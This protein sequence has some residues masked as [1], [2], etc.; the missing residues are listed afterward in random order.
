M[1]NYNRLNNLFPT[2]QDILDVKKFKA[3]RTYPKAIE[4][5]LAKQRAFEKKYAGFDLSKDGRNLMY[6]PLNLQV[7]PK[8]YKTMVLKKEYKRSF[9]SGIVNFYKTIREKFLNIKRTDV[10]AFIKGQQIPQLTDIMRHRTN[11]PIVADYPNQIWCIDLIDMSMYETKNKGFR[12]ILTVID[13]FSRKCFLDKI[14]VK[15]ALVTARAMDQITRKTTVTPKYIIC[16]NGTEFLGEFITFCMAHDIT[17]RRNRAYSPEANGIVERANKEVRK[18]IRNINLENESTNWIDYL[19]RVEDI[20]NNTYT[21]AIKNIPNKIWNNKK[22][23]IASRNIPIHNRTGDQKE[24]QIIANQTILR[25]VKKQIEEFKDDELEVGDQVRVRMDALSNG[26]KAL[27]KA[28]K[29]KQIVVNFSPLVFK[30]LKKVIPK[31]GILERSRY[32][33]GTVDETRVLVNKEDG[34]KPRQFYANVLKKVGDD[35][36]N[37]KFLTMKT[38]VE[39]SGAELTRNDVYSAPYNG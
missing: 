3:T 1:T 36:T 13:V 38:A 20:K 25:N 6:T 27:V 15:E 2:D 16:D 21:S 28:G 14:K 19:Q 17:I 32:I 35:E 4:D 5:S 34:T 33:V 8:I 23:E 31:K 37:Y 11:K 24:D 39:L 7:V 30:I 22:E 26:I 9:G 18:L 10:S 12:Y 29:T